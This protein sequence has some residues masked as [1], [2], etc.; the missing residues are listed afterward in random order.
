MEN[1]PSEEPKKQSKEE[2]ESSDDEEEEE[3]VFT[4]NKP[5]CKNEAH[6]RCPTCKKYNILKESFFC[7]KDCF[8]SYWSEHK[9]IHEDYEPIDDG[10][11][12]TGPLRRYKITPKRTVPKNIQLP[13]YA[14]DPDGKSNCEETADRNPFQE[15]PVYSDEDIEQMKIVCKIGRLVLDTVHKEV[16][17]GITTDELDKIV[18]ETAIENDC[19]PSP[20]NYYKFPKSVCTSVN[21]VICH[22]IPD[23]R[24]LKDGDIV[25][26]DVTVFH[27]GYHGDLNETYLVGNVDK[28]AKDLVTTTYNSLMKAIEICRPG[29]KISEIG[30]VISDYVHGRGF[31]VVKNYMGHGICKLFHTFPNVPHYKKNKAHGV[32]KPGN[33]FTIEP[34]IN[35]G[36]WKCVKWYDNWT[37]ATEDGKRSAQFEHTIL[38]TDTGC[39]VLTAR[40]DKS[41]VL[42]IFK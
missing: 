7:G 24:P 11:P 32:M 35:E 18:H 25:N 15:T 6:L 1:K 31:S 3:Q 12:Y 41:P 9:K 22:G 20:L 10:F 34:M 19:Y 5:G 23:K 40:N 16:K 13:D 14:N 4:C 26:L 28:K 39:E 30:N 8:K 36:T 37:A 38:I 33:I 27:H 21:E 42:E 29:T 17:V 2:E